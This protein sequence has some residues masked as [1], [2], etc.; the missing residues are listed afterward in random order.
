[1]AT[2]ALF[3]VFVAIAWGI[4]FLL[5]SALNL[6]VAYHYSTETWATFKVFGGMG[7]MFVFIFAQAFF[8]SRH[9]PDEDPAKPVLAKADSQER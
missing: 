5:Q 7:L 2:H 8:I 1:M 6:W 3:L 4:F 9:L